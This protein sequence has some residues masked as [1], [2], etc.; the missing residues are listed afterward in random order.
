M[1]L[2]RGSEFPRYA[3]QMIF[4]AMSP[5]IYNTPACHMLFSTRLSCSHSLHY[6]Y[7][8]SESFSFWSTMRHVIPT[9]TELHANCMSD[10]RL[11]K[12][13][14]ARP[15]LYL[16]THLL[17][18]SPTLEL[19]LMSTLSLSVVPCLSVWA[20][21]TQ[22]HH[23]LILHLLTTVRAAAAGNTRLMFPYLKKGNLSQWQKRLMGLCVFQNKP[24]AHGLYHSKG[25]TQVLWL[26]TAKWYRK[27]ELMLHHSG[28]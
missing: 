19:S 8:M 15:L 13:P 17:K 9:F 22:K 12:S 28:F 24:A 6:S 25:S 2:L 26:F 7:F 21:R 14:D 3:Y 20:Y 11:S 27:P 4:A 16:Y 10:S 1:W 18:S 5:N 23:P